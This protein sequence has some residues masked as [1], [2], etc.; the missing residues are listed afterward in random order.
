MAP[1]YKLTYFNGRGLAETIRII[2][3]Y[4]DIEYEDNRF[5]REK[6]PEMKKG[7]SDKHY[8]LL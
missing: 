6:W 2:F 5:E 3:A 7:N 4:A 1:S 8:L